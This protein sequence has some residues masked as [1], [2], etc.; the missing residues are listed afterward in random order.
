MTAIA[1]NPKRFF[2]GFWHELLTDEAPPVARGIAP[3]GR[4]GVGRTSC[5]L[6]GVPVG[7]TCWDGGRRGRLVE[8]PEIVEACMNSKLEISPKLSGVGWG[9]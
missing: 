8:V 4:G 3:V 9:G 7:V 1:R 2:L 5:R 6:A